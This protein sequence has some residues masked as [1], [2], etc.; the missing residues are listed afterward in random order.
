ME[1]H[2]TAFSELEIAVRLAYVHFL[3]VE[4][5]VGNTMLDAAEGADEDVRTRRR[6]RA[7]EAHDEIVRQLARGSKLG[8]P[9]R[10][11]GEIRDGLA[12]LTKRLALVSLTANP[13]SQARAARQHAPVRER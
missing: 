2:F 7:Q 13:T 5:E 11:R 9:A 6:G 10:E 1:R 4:L 3:R 8:L 12:R